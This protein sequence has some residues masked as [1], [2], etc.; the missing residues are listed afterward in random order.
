MRDGLRIAR[1]EVAPNLLK[2]P[3]QAAETVQ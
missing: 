3:V 1:K 2:L